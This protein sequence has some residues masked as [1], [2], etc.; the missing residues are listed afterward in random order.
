MEDP[1]R[2]SWRCTASGCLEVLHCWDLRGVSRSM[3]R[4][5]LFFLSYLR[6]LF[7]ILLIII[8][9]LGP[10]LLHLLCSGLVIS[11]ESSREWRRYLH[12]VE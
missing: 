7:S 12:N 8:F 4:E 1:K 10:L 3:E 9:V 11:S 5:F 6:L 2:T